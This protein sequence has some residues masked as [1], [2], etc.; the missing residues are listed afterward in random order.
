MSPRR[1]D[2]VRRLAAG[3]RDLA[4]LDADVS[5]CRACPRL[6]AWREDVA[7]EKRALVRRA[8]PTGAGRSPGWGAT[9]P[10]R[11]GRRARPGR[12]R[13]QPDRPDLHR[14]PLRRLAVR[15][16]APRRP[17]RAADERAR[18]RRAAADRHPDG[19]GGALRTAGQQADADERDTCA[20]WLDAELALRAARACAR[21]SSRVVR[22]GR[23]AAG[24]GPSRARGP[25]A[26]PAVR[27]RREVASTAR[28]RASPCSAAT[29]PASRTPSPASSP[30]RCSTQSSARRH[31]LP[32]SRRSTEQERS[33]ASG[34]PGSRLRSTKSEPPQ[35]GAHHDAALPRAAR[36]PHPLRA[37]DPRASTARRARWPTCGI[38]DETNVP[39]VWGDDLWTLHPPRGCSLP[40][41]LWMA[42]REHADSFSD[43][44]PEAQATSAS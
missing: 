6:V 15:V 27:A 9:E 10:R 21:S 44:S 38:C 29:T 33:N 41:A 23:R 34:V 42:S 20:P 32:A 39:R 35:S 12:A 43:L 37:G 40:G 25:A 13:R 18:G 8:S 28:R 24:A 5:V 14:R 36:A 1:S 16:A 31:G 3:A 17:G 2:D 19:R 22:L 26:A 7:V 4:T 11:A 30:S